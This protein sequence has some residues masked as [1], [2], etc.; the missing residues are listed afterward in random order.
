MVNRWTTDNVQAAK[1]GCTVDTITLSIEQKKYAEK[2]ILTEGLEHRINVHLLDYRS[3]PADFKGKF[4]AFV[5]VEMIEVWERFKL[6]IP[7]KLSLSVQAVGV[8]FL[9]M[10]FAIV[11]W[12]LKPAKATAVIAAST[13]PSWRFSK[14]QYESST[15]VEFTYL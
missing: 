3:L 9:E 15:M 1:M 7:S 5:S 6:N 14:Y 4:D 13:Q 2:R 12:A 11:D 10:Y 8:E